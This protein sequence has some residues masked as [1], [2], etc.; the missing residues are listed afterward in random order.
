MDGRPYLAAGYT[1]GGAPHG[2]CP[3]EM[4]HDHLTGMIT[5]GTPDKPS[6]LDLSGP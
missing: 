2:T 6:D 5:P 3:G 1:P 4:D